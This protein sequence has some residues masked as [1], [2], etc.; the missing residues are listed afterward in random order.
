MNRPT[1]YLYD[2]VANR[3]QRTDA[4]GLVVSYNYD[5][6]RRLVSI[7][8]P[9][10]G[11]VTN[12][13]DAAGQKVGMVD[14]T[15]ATSYSYD[16]LGRQSS[17][18]YPIGQAL[19]YSY[20]AIG[21]RTVM[22]SSSGLTSYAYDAQSRLT[23]IANPYGEVTT[24]SYD[25]LSR[26]A[27]KFLANGIAVNHGYDTVGREVLL[28]QRR[29]DGTALAVYTSTYDNVGNRLSILEGDGSRTTYTY[30]ASYRLLG[31]E[32]SGSSSFFTSFTYDGLGNRLTQSKDGTLTTYTHDATNAVTSATTGA[33][34]TT[35]SYDQNGNRVSARAD[36]VITTF[37][38]DEENRMVGVINPDAPA[39][40]FTYSGD[41]QRRSKSTSSGTIQYLWDGENVLEEL[42]NNGD[43]IAHYTD[44]S[45]YWG[46]LTS[47][48]T[49]SGL[50]GSFFYLFDQQ[51]STRFLLDGTGNIANSDLYRAFGERVL[52]TGSARDP[53]RF[54][55]QVR[56]YTDAANRVWMGHRVYDPETGSWFSIDPIGFE[57]EDWNL[58][59]FV[60]SNPVIYIDPSGLARW[61]TVERRARFVYSHAYIAFNAPCLGQKTFGFWPGPPDNNKQESTGRKSGSYPR[62]RYTGGSI[63]YPD[64]D[65]GAG[66][67][68]AANNSAAF[69]AALC[70]CI[71]W[72]VS[73]QKPYYI[74]PAYMCGSWVAEMWQCAKMGGSK[75]YNHYLDSQAAAGIP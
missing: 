9:D 3:I 17:V 44:Y 7:L 65:R 29:T 49:T 66:H 74:F 36:G 1:S 32:R 22:A 58:Y 19:T 56:S 28:E 67:A 8:Y 24:L 27:Q 34:V 60:K 5:E 26:E 18:V 40:T 48:F 35:Y 23:N 64:P 46:G 55:G 47:L 62:G 4:R 61:I 69:E 31:E 57:G 37:S 75:K 73:I 50:G 52:S 30:D 68:E 33:S 63:L 71:K 59:R 6:G 45:S 38:W 51:A 54:Q 39:E 12:I 16:V 21:N 43:L 2:G 10:G 20:D 25:A 13:Y 41:G 72:S 15:G 11:Y 42:N 70:D 53:H 14:R